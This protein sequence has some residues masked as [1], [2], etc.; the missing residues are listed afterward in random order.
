M[1]ERL[2]AGKTARGEKKMIVYIIKWYKKKDSLVD[3]KVFRSEIEAE[4][5]AGIESTQMEMDGW[6]Y[7]V[8]CCE[9]QDATEKPERDPETEALLREQMDSE[10]RAGGVRKL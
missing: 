8:F 2:T 6:K 10:E 4:T 1:K 5:Y 3:K 9:L 7:F